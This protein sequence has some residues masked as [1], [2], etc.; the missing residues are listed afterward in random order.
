MKLNTL[1]NRR[2]G[3]FS[4]KISFIIFI[5]FL[6]V[7]A[8]SQSDTIRYEAGI[9]TVASTGS[10]AP[11]WLH[12]D[13]YGKISSSPMS[14]LVFTG[15]EKQYTNRRNKFDYGFKAGAIVRTDYHKNEIFLNEIYAKARYAVFYILAGSREQIFGN[16]DST[17]SSGGLLFSKNARPMPEISAGIENFTP[18]PFTFGL[19]ELKGSMR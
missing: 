6:S 19:L 4:K 15:I 1:H 3:K 7:A 5:S 16:Q 12:S 9:A 2:F 11:F 13:R 14:T 18:V 10:Y 8:F 17:L